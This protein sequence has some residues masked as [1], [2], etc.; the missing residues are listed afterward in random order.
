MRFL[1][2]P[3]DYVVTENT[4]ICS[5]HFESKFLKATHYFTRLNYHPN[6]VPAIHPLSTP[7]NQ[8]IVPTNSRPPP[9]KR[10]FQTDQISIYEE[11]FRIQKFQDVIEF[12]E[13]APEYSSLKLHIEDTFV[14]AYNLAISSGVADVKECITIYTDFQVKL[15]YEGSPIPLPSY[16]LNSTDHKL[17][18]LDALEKL[19]NYC[20]NFDSKFD[21]DVIKELIHLRY[22][23]PRGR[24]KY[25]SQVLRFSL[26]LRY[27]SNSAYNLLKKYIPLPSY[28]LLRKLKS[29]SIDNC[30]ALKFL[31]DSNSI[32]NDIAILLD[33]MHLQSQVQFDGHTLVGCN[34]DLEMYT[35]ILCFIVVSLRKSIP[36]VIAAVPLVRNSGNIVYDNL[37]KCLL[38][39]TQSQF[40]IRAIVSDNHTTNV[41]AYN[42]LQTNYKI[43]DKDYEIHNPYHSVENIYLLFDTCHLIKN[44]RNNLVANKFFDIPSFQFSSVNFNLSFQAGFV[45]VLTGRLQSDPLDGIFSHYRQMSGGRFLVSLQEVITSESMIKWK[46]LLKRNIE[47]ISLSTPAPSI[48][49]MNALQGKCSQMILIIYS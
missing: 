27:T 31:R 8:A 49:T 28:S 43:Q 4:F 16:N 37:D 22:F 3:A 38:L 24:P 44:I 40:K 35:S 32:G 9:K 29:P 14:T 33:E 41:K 23:S 42:R 46:S 2:R 36:F 45:Y 10:V 26:M 6:P 20:R 34:A 17:T 5:I 21:I 47:I 25:S 1:N 11:K 18:H 39:L 30:Q 48:S 19:P 12:L 15:T 13:D 7:Q